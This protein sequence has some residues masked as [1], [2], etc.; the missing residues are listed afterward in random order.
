VWHSYLSTVGYVKVS[1]A[2]VPDLHHFDVDPYPTFHTDSIPDPNPAPEANC[3][4]SATT[5]IQIL[6]GS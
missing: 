6:H 3:G 1:S 5:G 2:S 4:K